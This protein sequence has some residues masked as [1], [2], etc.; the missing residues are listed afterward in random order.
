MKDGEKPNRVSWNSNFVD[1]TGSIVHSGDVRH[2]VGNCEE[3]VS[4]DF[5]KNVPYTWML[6]GVQ[7]YNTPRLC[8]LE[9][10][11]GFRVGEE[12]VYRAKVNLEEKDFIGYLVN[13]KEGYVKFI[14]EGMSDGLGSFGE[15]KF[16]QY[17]LK[18]SLN[19]KKLLEDYIKIKGGILMEEPDEET[20]TLPRNAWELSKLLLD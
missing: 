17:I 11:I 19:L 1:I 12:V 16:N 15:T 18:K 2:V 14:M 9:N 6:V 5:S 8:D 13:L 7:N 3:Y 4:V 10:Y 20:E